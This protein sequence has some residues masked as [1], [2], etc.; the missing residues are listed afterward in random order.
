MIIL[1]VV[2]VANVI[3]SSFSSFD[4]TKI[5]DTLSL[6]SL[7]HQA[8]SKSVVYKYICKVICLL[9]SNVYNKEKQLLEEF[10]AYNSILF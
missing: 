3:G 5:K 1:A 7:N 10:Q 9:N 4:L 8:S 6:T 2:V